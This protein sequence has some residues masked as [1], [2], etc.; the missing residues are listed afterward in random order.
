MDLTGPVAS[1][2]PRANR[3]TETTDTAAAEGIPERRYPI[4]QRNPP[5]FHGDYKKWDDIRDDET[6]DLTFVSAMSAIIVAEDVPVSLSE[7]CQSVDGD[8]WRKAIEEELS[9][10]NENYTWDVVRK[11]TEKINIIDSTRVFQRK[12]EPDGSTRYKARLVA[13]GCFQRKGIDYEETY[14]PVARLSTV[15]TVLS[16]GLHQSFW[17]LRQHF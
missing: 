1:S 15:R 6:D 13:R 4:R 2:T 5:A 11:P 14:S 17:I 8:K 7:A 16:V 3:P 9:A 10:H 12:E